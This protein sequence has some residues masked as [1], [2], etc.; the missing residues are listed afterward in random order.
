M[1]DARFDMSYFI[2]IP[3]SSAV[4]MKGI[5]QLKDW[6]ANLF[7]SL[8]GG[9]SHAPPALLRGAPPL[10]LT[11]KSLQIFSSNCARTYPLLSAQHTAAF[12]TILTHLH[13]SES[14]SGKDL[15]VIKYT[16]NFLVTLVASFRHLVI[17]N[18]VH[19]II[20]LLPC[21]SMVTRP[22]LGMTY[23]YSSGSNIASSLELSDDDLS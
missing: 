16:S 15:G 18:H 17:P 10:V 22:S 4:G 7:P 19:C 11:L 2:V 12:E 21:L 20:H 8:C 5:I 13:L 6:S 3:H 23:L 9:A 1:I 14:F